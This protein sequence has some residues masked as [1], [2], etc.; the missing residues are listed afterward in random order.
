MARQWNSHFLERAQAFMGLLWHDE[1]QMFAPQKGIE[2]AAL[3][4]D[5]PLASII[6]VSGADTYICEAKPGTAETEPG[7]RIQKVTVSGGVTSITWAN[8]GRFDQVAANRASL[9]YV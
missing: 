5:M 1:N 9:S 2:G 6:E 7:W 3:V 8:G 4:S